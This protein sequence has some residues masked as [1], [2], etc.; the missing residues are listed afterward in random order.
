MADPLVWAED[1][2]YA[3][4]AIVIGG[5][6]ALL[7]MFG[8]F[9]SSNTGASTA[10]TNLASAYYAAEAAQATAGTNLNIV[11]DQTQAQTA[12]VAA[13]ANA[14]VAI[15]QANATAA[16]NI[17]AS[18][19]G[20]VVQ[21]TG[22][23][24]AAATT[25]AQAMY[26]AQVQQAAYGAQTAQVQANDALAQANANSAYA[27]NTT[28]ANNQANEFLTYLNNILPGELA[29]TGGRV[30]AI[31]PGGTLQFGGSTA[32]PS[33]YAAEGYSPTQIARIFGG[34]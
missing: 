15:N 18:Q 34:A 17:S 4:A 3:T 16:Q 13:Q 2:P 1:H 11:Q 7:W 12:Q 20:A 23:T 33:A 19:Y 8:F 30:T 31:L 6:L 10:T 22:L 21:E 24:T 14:A 28:V 9:G 27:Y 25:Q 5:G 32:G 26:G 29:L